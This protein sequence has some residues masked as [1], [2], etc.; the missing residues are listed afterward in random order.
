MKCEDCKKR[1]AVVEYSD[2]PIFALSHGWGVTSICRQCYIKRIEK[3]MKSLQEN[4]EKQKELL[5]K[6]K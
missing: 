6:N 4:L 1:K 3:G 2:E 5:K